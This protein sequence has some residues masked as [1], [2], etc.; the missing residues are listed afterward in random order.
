M[1]DPRRYPPRRLRHQRA[2]GAG[3]GV[4]GGWRCPSRGPLGAGAGGARDR[5]H[6]LGHIIRCGC[7]WGPRLVPAELVQHVVTLTALNF[8]LARAGG[9]GGWPAG[10]IRPPWRGRAWRC[11][12]SVLCYLPMA[13]RA[14]AASPARPAGGRPRR[15][16]IRRS[17]GRDNHAAKT[18]W[19][20]RWWRTAL[21][22][23]LVF[24]HHRAGGA[25][26][27]PAQVA[28]RWR[29][30]GAGA[31]GLGVL[32]AAAGCRS[33]FIGPYEGRGG[34]GPAERRRHPARRALGRDG[35][36]GAR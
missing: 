24:R 33:R 36:A 25:L 26:E 21:L 6:L 19:R 13:G 34:R 12:S 22:V 3:A 29:L 2:D 23:T 17:D 35:R 14:A 4:A 18:P 27:D 1:A 32:T 31:E 15:H 11:G 7:L 8:N 20:T 30:C 9:A 16:G 10:V 5:R 28:G